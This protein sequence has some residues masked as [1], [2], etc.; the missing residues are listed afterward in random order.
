[1]KEQIQNKFLH[2]RKI[3][4]TYKYGF[5]A[6]CA[7]DIIEFQKNLMSNKLHKYN[8]WNFNYSRHNIFPDVDCELEID[9]EIDKV[10]EIMRLQIDSHVMVQSITDYENYIGERDYTID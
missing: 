8:G 3:T 6:E 2:V 7:Y 5:R 9:L 4:P 1:M 10:R